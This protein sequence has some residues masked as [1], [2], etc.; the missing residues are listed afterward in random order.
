[1]TQYSPGLIPSS[2]ANPVALGSVNIY[3]GSADP[4]GSQAAPAGSFYLR[5]NG[6]VY[7]KDSGSGNTGWLE[8]IDATDWKR[9][10]KCV[11]VTIAD[12]AGAYTSTETIPANARIV[13]VDKGALSEVFN[14][15]PTLTVGYTGALNAIAGTSDTDLT[16]ATAQILSMNKAWDST[17]RAVICTVGGTPDQGAGIIYVHY[18]ETIGT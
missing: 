4:E 3:S 12:P 13:R 18:I 10:T 6:S 17:A 8:L 14:N 9:A 5:T 1:M 15:T 16:S 11:Q 7:K 2:V